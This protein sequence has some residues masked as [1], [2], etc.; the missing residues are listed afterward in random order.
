MPELAE[1]QRRFGPPCLHELLRREG[2]VQNRKLAE[3][4]IRQKPFVAYSQTG[5]ASKPCR[6]VWADLMAQMSNGR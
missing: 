6:I 1:D 3:G 2:L 4:V 5:E